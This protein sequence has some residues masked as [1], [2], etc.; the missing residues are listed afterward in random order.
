MIK[1]FFKKETDEIILEIYSKEN[2]QL[3]DELKEVVEKVNKDINF[4]IK[5]IDITK[6]PEIFEKYKY[7]IPV[8][9]INGIIAFK[10]RITE[11]ELRK[12]LKTRNLL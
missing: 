6:D 5:E 11:T 10:H 4:Q 3:C 1:N 9:H 7:D 2:C 12:K 8:V